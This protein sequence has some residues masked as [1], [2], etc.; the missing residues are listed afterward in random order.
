MSK[1]FVIYQIR[2]INTNIEYSYIGST[3]NLTKR[4]YRHKYSS[5][6]NLNQLPVYQFIREHGG[7][8]EFE[9]VPLEEIKCESKLQAR[10][11]EQ[12]WIDKI[13]CKLNVARAF[14]DDDT[15]RQNVKK[16][17]EENKENIAIQ[18]KYHYEE[19]KAL[20]LEKRKDY[21]AKKYNIVSEKKREKKT[22]CC[23]A[24][25]SNCHMGRHRRTIKHLDYAK[26]INNNNN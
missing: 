17:R 23:G 10:I 4:K 24:V 19:N 18:R 8:S 22:C 2:P 21:C 7:W 6:D 5:N 26:N 25:V 12:G 15:K 13:E 9:I 11:K 1:T 3:Q 16:Y 14:S 20:L